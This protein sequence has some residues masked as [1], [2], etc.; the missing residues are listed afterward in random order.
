MI[1][2]SILPEFYLAVQKEAIQPK[3]KPKGIE[4]KCLMW[5]G[6]IV[7]QRLFSGVAEMVARPYLSAEPKW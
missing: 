6:K 4:T 5:E 3:A 2:H 1:F 7:R